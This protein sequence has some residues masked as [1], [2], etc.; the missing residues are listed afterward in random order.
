VS[1]RMPPQRLGAAVLAAVLGLGSSGC[2]GTFTGDLTTD[3]PADPDIAEVRVNL[4]GLRFQKSGGAT[5]TLEFNDPEPVDLLELAA[6]GEPMRLFTDEPLPDGSYT[7]VRLMFEDEDDVDGSVVDVEGD[8]FPLLLEDGAYASA[9]FTVTEDEN[10]SHALELV[11]DLRQSLAFDDDEYTLTPVLR[12]V[13]AGQAARIAGLVTFEC[14]DGTS[15]E[16]GGAVYLFEGHD[17]VPDDL[18]G[19]GAEPHATTRVRQE[20][21]DEQFSY[22][23]RHLAPGDYTLGLTCEGDEDVVNADDSLSFRR[24]RNVS[25]EAAEALELDLD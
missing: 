18:D 23:L 17:V 5:V 4:R 24:V 15:L 21:A 25:L 11:L 12:A 9:G 2:E 13:K 1:P 22:A 19:A 7:G 8:E 3:A 16:R 10:S 6:D 14:P 20:T